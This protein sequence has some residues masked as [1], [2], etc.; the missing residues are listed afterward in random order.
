MKPLNIPRLSDYRKARLTDIMPA[1]YNDPAECPNGH[2]F[3]VQRFRSSSGDF[4][5]TRCPKCKKQFLSE[6]GPVP[7]DRKQTPV[8]ESAIEHRLVKRVKELGGEVRK[9]KWEGRRGAPD[10][11]V[12]LPFS[13]LMSQRDPDPRPLWVELKKPGKAAKFPSTPHE[14]A[15]HR[16]HERMRKM[17]Q[18]VEVVD[19]FERIEEILS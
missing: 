12:M 10:R 13:A 3:I 4:I 1:K 19:S 2:V 5:A 6:A 11:L 16:E 14:H 18:R 8:R 17:G 15:Q 9:V 7:E